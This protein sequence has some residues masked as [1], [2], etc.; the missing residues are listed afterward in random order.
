VRHVLRD[1]RGG[2]DAIVMDVDNGAEAFTTNGNAT[3]YHDAGIA[4][5]PDQ[6]RLAPRRGRDR[7]RGQP[8]QVLGA[9]AQ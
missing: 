2:F 7:L 4:P 1:E 3:L 6:R 9:R 5:Q 8:R